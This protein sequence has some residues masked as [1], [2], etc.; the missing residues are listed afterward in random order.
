VPNSEVKGA[1]SSAVPALSLRHVSKNFGGPDVLVDAALDV[2]PSEIH[3]LVGQNGSGKSTLIKILSGY[4]FPAP[5]AEMRLFGERIS[6]PLSPGEFRGL[7]MS[8]VHQNLGLSPHMSV[9]DNVRVGRYGSATLGR[10][11]WKQERRLVEEAL[12]K[13][14]LAPDLDAAVGELPEAE[15]AIVAIARAVQQIE[16]VALPRGHRG[17]LIL[18]EPTPYLSEDAVQSLFGAM[19]EVAAEGTACLFVSHRLEEIRQITDRVTVLRDGR[20]VATRNSGEV[21]DEEMIELIVGSRLQEEERVRTQVRHDQVMTVEGLRGGRVTEISF[22]LHQ[23][24]I[25]GVT[26]LLGMG[27]EDLPYLLTGAKRAEHGHLTFQGRVLPLARLSPREALKIGL[28]LVPA[29][30]ERAGAV[31]LLTV[32]ENMT[33]PRVGEFFHGF[34]MDYR[35]EESVAWKMAGKFN[36]RPRDPK[37]I[38]GTLSGGNQQKAILAKWLSTNPRVLLLHEPTQGVDVGARRQILSELENVAEA[39]H[40]VIVSSIEYEELATLC[41]RVLV[42]REGRLASELKGPYVTKDRIL[43]R[44]Y[45]PLQTGDSSHQ[46]QVG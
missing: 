39:G 38:F 32:G 10:I 21:D 30:R 45:R 41:D 5:G 18:D 2:M 40:G 31:F 11:R 34:R 46:V 26:G 42:M 43:E 6:L 28:A 44:S 8:F 36:V 4:H 16:E 24:E 37:G 19:R 17:I 13:F 35:E 33:L 3:G 25:L 12:N 14:G 27:F 23:G 9:L 1:D 20:V 7:G 15:Q 22:A 29:N